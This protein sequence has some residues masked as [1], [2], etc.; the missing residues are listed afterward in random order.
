MALT[1]ILIT[2]MKITV[3]MYVHQW[4]NN[5]HARIKRIKLLL[6]VYFLAHL[7]IEKYRLLHEI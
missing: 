1:Q 4:N 6:I 5:Y 2:F 7:N 3:H